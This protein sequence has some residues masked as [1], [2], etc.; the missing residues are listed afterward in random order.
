MRIL[1]D[2]NV[3]VPLRY[4]LHDHEV[5]ATFER[6]WEKLLNGELINAAE[7]AGFD[8]L[9]T[10][11]RALSYQQNWSGRKLSLLI[12]STNDWARIRTATDRVLVAVNSIAISARIEL[13]IEEA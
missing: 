1:L 2:H 8:L 6:A 12:L 13:N 11:D 3:P 5:E 7:Q 10:T 9:I 4:V